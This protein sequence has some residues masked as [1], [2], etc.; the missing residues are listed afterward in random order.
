[1]SDR[2]DLL[3]AEI[4]VELEKLQDQIPPFPPEKARELVAENLGSPVES[5][6]IYFSDKPEGA[7][8]LAQVHR[9]L[10]PT[11]EAVA[12][13]IKRPGIDDLIH[14]D[15]AIMRQLARFIDK[16]T[17]L[18]E[19]IGAGEIVEEFANQITRELDFTEELLNIKRFRAAYED[20]SHIFVPKTYDEYTTRDLLVMEFVHGRKV[21]WVIRSDDGRFDKPLINRRTAEFVMSQLF[22][23][24]LFH[25]DPHPGN[26]LVKEGNIICF[27]DYGMVFSLRPYELEHLNYLMIGLARFD[28]VLVGRSLLRMGRAEGRVDEDEFQSVVHDYIHSHLDRPVESINVSQAFIELLQM[29][30]NF[31]VRLPPRLVYVAKVIGGLQSIASGLDPQFN[32]IDSIRDFSTRIWAEQFASNRTGNKILVS[33]LD[34]GSAVL[35]FPTMISDAR[36]FLRDRRL[37]MNMPEVE[38]LRETFDR[39]GFRLSFGLVLSAILISSALVVLADIEPRVYGVPLFG[40]FGFALG[41]LMGIGFLFSGIIRFFKWRSGK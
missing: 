22:I 23:K 2:K 19:V 33:A 11:G 37:Q 20:D 27:I 32:L 39:V 12:V 3:P 15:L 31:G 6:F 7:A 17:G 1:M 4:L 5:N 28:P 9:A 35:S 34:W 36:R 29:V 26:F 14:A 16:N 41:T 40:I 10:L 21:S 25:A 30:T 8:S 38:R 18:F 24:G 13:K